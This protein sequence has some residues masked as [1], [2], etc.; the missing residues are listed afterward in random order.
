MPLSLAICF[1]A[2]LP[3]R[4]CAGTTEWNNEGTAE[5]HHQHQFEQTSMEAGFTPNSIGWTRFET[6][7][8]TGFF[9]QFGLSCKHLGTS[10]CF[11]DQ[12]HQSQIPTLRRW[13]WHT[14]RCW[15]C[16]KVCSAKT[17]HLWLPHLSPVRVHSLPLTPWLDGVRVETRCFE[18]RYRHHGGAWQLDVIQPSAPPHIQNAIYMV[19]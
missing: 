11:L 2:P 17:F 14:M 13:L 6:S 7:V 8:F 19:E 3:R 4:S 16:E 9:S 10:V 12:M 18:R 1:A 15:R 5:V